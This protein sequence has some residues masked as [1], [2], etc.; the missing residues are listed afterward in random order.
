ME[1]VFGALIKMLPGMFASHMEMP[2]SE[3][4]PAPY[5]C[6]LYSARQQQVVTWVPVSLPPDREAWIQF[7]PKHG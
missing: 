3:S 7:Q 5:S 6:F 2:M 1:W 4:S